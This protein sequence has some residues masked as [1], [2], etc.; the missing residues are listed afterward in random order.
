MT[1]ILCSLNE[2]IRYFAN[3]AKAYNGCLIQLKDMRHKTKN[4]S[5][6]QK[7]LARTQHSI[8]REKHKHIQDLK[9]QRSTRL[10]RLNVKI[11]LIEMSYHQKYRLIHT[12]IKASTKTSEASSTAL[13]Q[14]RCP[15]LP[16]PQHRWMPKNIIQIVY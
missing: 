12:F 16:R 14:G 3:Y 4:D 1:K 9:Y 11:K 10:S 7:N 6:T 2:L 13:L 15:Y 8:L 5:R